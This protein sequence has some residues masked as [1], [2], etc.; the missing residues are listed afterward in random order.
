MKMASNRLEKR[1][2]IRTSLRAYYLQNGFNYGNYQGLGY[3]NMLFPALRKLYRDDDGRLQEALKEN[4]EFFNTNLHFVPF[5][6]SL[7]LVM[8]ENRTPAKEI[9]SIKMALM[10]PLAGIGDSLAQFCL[11]PL[12]ATIGASLAQEG[13]ILGP[14]LFFLAMN[15]ILLAAKVLTGL[16]GYKLGTNI[17]ASL[18]EKMEMISGIASMIGVTVIS[19]LAV[20]FVKIATP[21]RYV[22]SMPDNQQKVVAIQDMVDAIAPNLL[23][24]LFTGLIFYLIKVKKWTT[25]RLVVLTIVLGI[26]LSVLHLIA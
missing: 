6:T 24:V 5:I 8:L 21:V 26:V 4:I 7:H 2:Y 23:P 13:M 11:A 15:G 14:V 10:G 22:A 25:Y 20:N 9:R 19:G 3:A 17:I 1:D 18:S 16:W 12:F